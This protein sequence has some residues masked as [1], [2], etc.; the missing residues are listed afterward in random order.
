MAPE[1]RLTTRFWIQAYR[2]RLDLHNLPVF[3]R[4]KGDQTAGAVLVKLNTLDGQAVLYQRGFSLDGPR[5]WD[6]L[7]EGDEASVEAAIVQQTGFDPD[8]WVLEVESAEGRTLLDEPGL[9]E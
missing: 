1:P 8:I 7:C 5:G 6:V 3:V 4:K 9:R 2:A